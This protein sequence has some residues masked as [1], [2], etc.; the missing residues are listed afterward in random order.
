MLFRTRVVALECEYWE[1][2]MLYNIF[3]GIGAD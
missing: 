3:V 2:V 1:L